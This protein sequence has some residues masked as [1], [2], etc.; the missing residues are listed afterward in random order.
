MKSIRLLLTLF[1]TVF[2]LSGHAIA[3]NTVT[4][5]SISGTTNVVNY[6]DNAGTLGTA[7]V[8]YSGLVLNDYSANSGNNG[9][10]SSGMI[11]VVI[12]DPIKTVPPND[13]TAGHNGHKIL[14][15]TNVIDQGN[16]PSSATTTSTTTAPV[17]AT[18]TTT[19]SSTAATVPTAVA[20]GV[21]ASGGVTGTGIAASTT[22]TLSGTAVT[23]SAAATTSTGTNS[24]TFTNYTGTV[25]SATGIPASGYVTGQGIQPG[26]TY[27][28]SS[29]TVTFNLATTATQTAGTLTFSASPFTVSNW[30]YPVL[31][32]Q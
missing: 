22:Y 27:T 21:P 26:T 15:R 2:A 19:S 18:G 30:R 11:D 25:S 1:A 14:F 17:T 29:T 7:G 6:V 12:V 28:I 31:F 10:T 13:F 23:L 3:G 4:R 24:L 16:L 8:V 32:T 9:N 20:A 5:P